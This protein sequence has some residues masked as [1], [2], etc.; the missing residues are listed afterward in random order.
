VR[1]PAADC[2][3][4]LQLFGSE[5][6]YV[7]PSGM[8]WRRFLSGSN[9]NDQTSSAYFKMKTVN[10]GEKGH[11]NNNVDHSTV[12]IVICFRCLFDTQILQYL[13]VLG[14]RQQS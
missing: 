14:R 12:S 13:K 4:I 9:A 2:S 10:N 3:L 7:S 11:V 5:K 8:N 6:N 1:S